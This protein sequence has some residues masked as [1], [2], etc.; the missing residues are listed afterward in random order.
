[1]TKI[2]MCGLTSSDD[3][4]A[5]NEI[6][7]EYIGFVFCSTSRR[8]VSEEK[9]QMLKSLL[10]DDIIAVGVFVDEDIEKVAALSNSGLIGAVQLH[11]N[12]D[13]EYILRLKNMISAPVIKAFVIS[14]PDDVRRAAESPADYVLLDSGSGSGR[15]FDWNII[16]DLDRE[17]FLAGGL[18]PL[19][20]EDAVNRLHP[21]ACDVSSGI[22]TSHVKDK[23]KMKAFADA[24]RKER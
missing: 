3:I 21:Y 18:D 8:Y 2:K 11:G 4:A 12:E 5:V 20:A 23:N 1:M 15:T 19:T 16:G 10:D 14:S 6:R 9:A 22:E 24:V 7:P 17:Y 13:D